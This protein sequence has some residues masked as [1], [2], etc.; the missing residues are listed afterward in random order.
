[1]PTQPKFQIFISSTF[2]D[3]Q[4]ERDQIIK[5]TLEMGHIPVGM[6]MFSAADDEQ[7]KIIAKHI[8]ES[9][10]YVII[11]AHRLGS[12]AEN[13]LSYT[14]KEYEYAR[15][16]K[17]PILGFLIDEKA[18]WEAHRF[19]RGAHNK[20]LLDEFK[21]L[22]RE[23]PV[24]FW[25]N[26]DDLYGKFSV[27]LMKTIASTPRSGWVRASTGT[28]APEVAAEVVRLSSENAGL[29]QELAS[30]KHEADMEH[31]DELRRALDTLKNTKRRFSYKYSRDGEWQKDQEV[32]LYA[33]FRQVA[34][35]MIVESTIPTLANLLAMA[36]RTDKE[37]DW[38]T[39]AHNQMRDFM[40]DLLTL[41]LTQPSNR[42]HNINNTEVYWSLSPTGIE[43]L[44]IIRK[45]TLLPPSSAVETI[46]GVLPDESSDQDVLSVSSP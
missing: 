10:Y 17:I 27:S 42:N 37:A 35:E 5:A 14:R 4:D 32:T 15:K 43:A 34:A 38:F 28:V 23:K 39:V 36:I 11:A 33:A 45:T 20:E 2:E 46:D 21:D 18:S 31:K 3:L 41:E 16:L 22:I 19:E 25:S 24:S 6:E 40:A 12:M 9:D 29:R 26:A 1:M 44:K 13:G 30:I 8:E 7:W